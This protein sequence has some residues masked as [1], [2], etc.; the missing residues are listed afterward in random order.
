VALYGHGDLQPNESAWLFYHREGWFREPLA[1]HTQCRRDLV[2]SAHELAWHPDRGLCGHETARSRAGRMRFGS[3][4]LTPCPGSLKIVVTRTQEG[5]SVMRGW[6]GWINLGGD[7]T[8]SPAVVLRTPPPQGLRPRPWSTTSSGAAGTAPSGAGGSTS[9]ATSPAA[10]APFA[11]NRLAVFVRAIHDN[12]PGGAVLKEISRSRHRRRVNDD[13]GGARSPAASR[14]DRSESR[15]TPSRRRPHW[16]TRSPAH[17][18]APVPS[19][20]RR[21]RSA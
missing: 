21:K 2:T 17:A 8:P 5:V 19:L 4:W 18:S 11:A 1:Q 20:D 13:A 15:I 3:P 7:L 12:A 6:R 14:S 16:P 10:R 9:A